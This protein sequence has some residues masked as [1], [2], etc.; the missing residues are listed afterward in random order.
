MT[1][2]IQQTAT[3]VGLDI[4]TLK[5]EELPEPEEFIHSGEPEAE[6]QPELAVQN[7]PLN[8]QNFA[9]ALKSSLPVAIN[10]Q[11]LKLEVQEPKINSPVVY[12]PSSPILNVQY[13]PKVDIGKGIFPSQQELKEKARLFADQLELPLETKITA[14]QLKRQDIYDAFLNLKDGQSVIFCYSKEDPECEQYLND[15]QKYS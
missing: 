3:Q 13:A 9:G 6:I 8:A 11:Q 4:Q 14:E 2:I 12:D 1:D 10:R 7:Q 5:P 15:P